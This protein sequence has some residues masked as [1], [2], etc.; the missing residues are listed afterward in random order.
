MRRTRRGRRFW[1]EGRGTGELKKQERYVGRASEVET[2][3]SYV[4]DLGH[5]SKAQFDEW[6][7]SYNQIYGMLVNLRG[8]LK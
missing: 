2:W 8:S 4:F 7:R 6:L 3:I 1:S 5:I